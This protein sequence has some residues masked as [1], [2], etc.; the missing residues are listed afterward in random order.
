MINDFATLYRDFLKTELLDIAEQLQLATTNDTTSKVLVQKIIKDIEANGVPEIVD[1]SELMLE[2]LVAAEVCD[3]DGNL[4][5]GDSEGVASKIDSTEVIQEESLPEC[6]G[7]EDDRDPACNRCRV[8]ESC[9]ALRIQNRPP[10]FGRLFD[11]N[12]ESCKVCI[13][14]PFC[15]QDFDKNKVLV[16]RGK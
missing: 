15:L 5:D 10:C 7:F 2:F 16:K 11:K 13:E 1:C 3:V 12:D 9:K 14:A 8:Q 6:Y 4:L